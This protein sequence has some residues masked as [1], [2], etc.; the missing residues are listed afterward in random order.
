[1][2]YVLFVVIL[3]SL[4][5]C[6]TENEHSK[7][8][9]LNLDSL[10]KVYPDSVE[11][12]LLK[13]NQLL[14]KYEYSEAI[15]LGARA[16]RLDS[17]NIEARFLYANSLNNI[18]NRSVADVEQAQ[19]HFKMVI[20]K[21][22][23]NK[24]AYIALA[25]TCSQQGEFDK[26]F[27][28]INE[29]LRKDPKYHDAYVLNGPNYLTLGKRDYAISSYETAVQQDPNFFEAYLKLAW[30]Y[31]ED[32]KHDIAY[33]KFRTAYE[34]KPKSTDAIYGMAYSKQEM[35]KYEEALAEYRRL[36]ATDTAFYLAFFNQ[37]Y[38]KQFNQNQVDSAIF[39]YQR[40][41]DLQP[42]FVKGWHNL[43]LCY[44][45][46][47]DKMQALKCFSKALKYNPDFEM[48]RKEADKLMGK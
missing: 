48:S 1:M 20:K 35:G 36:I 12:L 25:S 39:F 29:V 6:S 42:E 32:L 41:I 10:V 23:E 43:G 34:L 40:A 14:D 24:Q 47:K 44:V 13:G 9:K 26:S 5:S 4:F 15:K 38:I 22:A 16:F 19:R 37:A 17:A 2:R 45:M 27:K 18:A 21:Q 33:E 31:S 11:L 3:L 7:P 30:I 8:S 28:Y 46:K